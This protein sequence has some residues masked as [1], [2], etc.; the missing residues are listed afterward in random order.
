VNDAMLPGD[1][2]MAGTLYR[3]RTDEKVGWLEQKEFGLHLMDLFFQAIWELAAEFL[4]VR[5]LLWIDTWTDPDAFVAKDELHVC[6]GV[7][8]FGPAE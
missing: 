8:G 5:V 6:G 2:F 4:V 7:D 3:R 1:S